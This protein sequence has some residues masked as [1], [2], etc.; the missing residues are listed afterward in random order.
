MPEKRRR[1]DRD[2]RDG[3]VGIVRETNKSVAQVARDLGLNP[4]T[5]TH[6]VAMDKIVARN[7][8]PKRLCPQ[9]ISGPLGQRG[10]KYSPPHLIWTY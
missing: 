2:L 10:G 9:A 6:W 4:G 1:Y 5:L 8:T 3:A 7:S